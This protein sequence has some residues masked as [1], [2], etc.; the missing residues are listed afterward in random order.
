MQ[1]W[2]VLPWHYI[3]SCKALSI[4]NVMGMFYKD[5]DLAMLLVKDTEKHNFRGNKF[6]FNLD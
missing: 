4:A 2:A 6:T 5:H 1:F 3:V